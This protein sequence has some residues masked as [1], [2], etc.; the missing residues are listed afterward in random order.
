MVAL[1]HKISLKQT[2]DDMRSGISIYIASF[3]FTQTFLPTN[4]RMRLN[5]HIPSVWGPHML[6][7]IRW[8]CQSSYWPKYLQWNKRVILRGSSGSHVHQAVLTFEEGVQN[9]LLDLGLLHHVGSRLSED[10]LPCSGFE[11]VPV[12]FNDGHAVLHKYGTTRWV[13]RVFLWAKGDTLL[14]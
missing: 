8:C 12:V 1:Q 7:G 10:E 5:I 11:T 2:G 3:S 9:P 4:W 14:P 6:C 13:C